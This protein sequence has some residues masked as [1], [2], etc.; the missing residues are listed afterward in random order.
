MRRFLESGGA[1]LDGRLVDVDT[2]KAISGAEIEAWMGTRSVETESDDQG[3]FRLE[4]L[5][6]GSRLNLWISAAPSF[7]QERTE[8][9]V[10]PDRPGF[11]ST[12]K[13]LSRSASA[14]AVDGGA[15]MFL[16]RRGSRT[17]V[18]GLAAFGPAEG[19]GVRVGDAIVAVAQR[20]V[21]ELGPGAI[22]FLLRGPIGS[23]VQLTV[24][25]G[26]QSPRRVTLRRSAR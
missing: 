18:T 11:Q 10:P 16:S 9:S 26:S 17:V 24:Q 21:G 22:D 15:G 2:G 6:P 23:E 3:R 5:V 19:A 13:M 7:V 1:A 4:G 20:K 14:G 25:T 8:V 12:F